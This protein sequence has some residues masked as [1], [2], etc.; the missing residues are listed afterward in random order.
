MPPLGSA[1]HTTSTSAPYSLGLLPNSQYKAWHYEC[2]LEGTFRAQD[3]GDTQCRSKSLPLC[4]CEA[5]R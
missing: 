5:P 2:L 4:S 3:S 1:G